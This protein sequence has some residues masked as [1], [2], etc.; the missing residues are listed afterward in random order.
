MHR[1]GS[2]V[3]EGRLTRWLGAGLAVAALAVL[4]GASAGQAG[5]EAHERA[6]TQGVAAS[7]ALLAYAYESG[8]VGIRDAARAAD[9][10]QRACNRGMASACTSLGAMYQSGVGV[11]RD[12]AR[13]Q[14][15]FRVACVQGDGEA[16]DLELSLTGSGDPAQL[17]V[18]R[19]EDPNGRPL[20]EAIVEVPALGLVAITG[21]DGRVDL[22]LLPAGRYDM[23]VERVGYRPVV[24]SIEVGEGARF[25]V[26]LIPADV[27]DPTAP[28]QVLGRVIDAGTRLGLPDVQIT[29]LGTTTGTLSGG[30]GGF[31]LRGVE[32]GLRRVRL[33]RI[34]Y[35]TETVM[36]VV[37]P[38]AA[39]E[40]AVSM[41]IQAI[42]LDAVDVMVSTAFDRRSFDVRAR[43]GWGT[44]YSPEEI[45]RIQPQRVSDLLRARVRGVTTV[46]DYLGTRVVSR[47][48][49][50]AMTDTLQAARRLGAGADSADIR[51]F[52]SG[53]QYCSL[54]IY[55]D[56]MPLVDFDIDSLDPRSIEA[57]EVYHG[58]GTPIQYMA[59]RCG[60]VLI[61]TRRGR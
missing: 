38:G 31:S 24:G 58:Q 57:V 25:V 19:V 50:S 5:T 22:G 48:S 30:G 4:P 7:C 41:S 36:V 1:M 34:G 26:P 3:G 21:L 12:L 15:L 55:L 23:R 10:Y 40:V 28:G 9:L 51:A 42:E 16:C 20:A 8:A 18:G 53:A 52:M 17:M 11:L 49:V 37:Q 56:G 14:E 46:T 33:E 39:V 54:A 6:C 47:R 60:A 2:R 13:A 44:H 61:W 35:G 27:P 59:N 32:P 43:L 29:V 45:D